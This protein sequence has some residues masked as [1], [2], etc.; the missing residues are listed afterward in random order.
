VIEEIKRKPDIKINIWISDIGIQ[1]DLYGNFDGNHFF[2]CRDFKA[3]HNRI[4]VLIKLRAWLV[5]MLD[6]FRKTH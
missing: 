6:I 5:E 3:D 4:D 2:I 1:Y